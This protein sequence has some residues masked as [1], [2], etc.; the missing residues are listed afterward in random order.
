VTGSTITITF[1]LPTGGVYDTDSALRALITNYNQQTLGDTPA[2]VVRTL[3]DLV[4]YFNQHFQFYGRK[5]VL[6]VYHGQGS[7]TS[8]FTDSGQ[9]QA[10][11]DALT[12]SRQYHAFADVSALSQPYSQALSTDHVVNIGSPYMS[13]QYYE[14]NAPYAYSFFPNCT[15]LANE[16]AA[17]AEKQLVGQNVTWGGEGV[18]DGQPRKIAIVAPD[19]PVYQQCA[20]LISNGLK[21]SGHPAALNLSYTLDI[22]QI[23]QEASSIEQQIVN[24]KITTVIWAGDPVTLVFLT[25]DLDNA[26]YVPEWLNWGAAFSDEDTISQLEDQT[27]WATAAGITNNGA[28]PAYG[29]S[30]GYFAAKSIDPSNPPVNDVDVFYEDLYILALGIQLAGPDLTPVNFEKGLFSY[31]GGEGQYGPWSFNINGTP[32]WTP[33][34]EFRYEWWDP[35]AI[36]AEDGDKGTWMSGSTWYTAARVPSGAL[37]VFPNGPQ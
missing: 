21:S 28:P 15:G 29:S 17:V 4:S 12:V 25:G 11:A 35:S 23:S 10:N 37:P 26:H 8:E 24:D 6:Q 31:P 19:N 22:T 33:Q 16:T 1:R 18:A 27:A 5:L 14:Q 13:R 34:Y 2:Q 3:G 20:S 32:S 30:L 9:A 36:S 7:L